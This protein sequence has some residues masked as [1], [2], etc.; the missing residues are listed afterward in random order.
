MIIFDV[1]L[2]DPEDPGGWGYWLN[3]HQLEHLQ[4]VQV[5]QANTHGAQ[6]PL[7]DLGIWRGSDEGT[8]SWMSDHEVM[9]LAVNEQTGVG[10][11]DF[12]E[13]DWRN[14]Y[15]YMVWMNN[16][17]VWHAQQRQKLGIK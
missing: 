3:R 9:T 15:S 11:P 12:G 5:I 7:F 1:T 17:A 4:F 2:A 16:H 13:A 14:P 10:N 6:L 8:D